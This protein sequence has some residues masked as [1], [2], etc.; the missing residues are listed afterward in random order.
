MQQYQKWLALPCQIQ[1]QPC[2]MAQLV[3]ATFL[4]HT[5]LA[6]LALYGAA[7]CQAQSLRSVVGM[8]VRLCVRPCVRA[9]IFERVRHLLS[10]LYTAFL[11]CAWVCVC[12][13]VY[14]CGCVCVF[15]KLYTCLTY[16]YACLHQRERER[17]CV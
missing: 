12:V 17:V 15:V 11:K 13:C 4:M 1:A 7:E 8:C 5:V 14:V 3:V 2:R 16:K 6:T 9:C 10:F